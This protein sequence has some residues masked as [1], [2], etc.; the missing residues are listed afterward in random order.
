MIYVLWTCRNREEAREIARALLE[1]RLIACASLLP[2]VGA[3]YRWKGKIEEGKEIKVFFKTRAS[4]F[5][6]VRDYILQ[7]SSY[8]VPEIVEIE[9]SRGNARY[10]AWVEEE[11]TLS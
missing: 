11:T 2:E 6:V 1:R 8:E 5:E 4:H 7:N 10:L 3:L 9:I